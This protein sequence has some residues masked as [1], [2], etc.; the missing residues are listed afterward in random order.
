LWAR[1]PKSLMAASS[2]KKERHPISTLRSTCLYSLQNHNSEHHPSPRQG[3]VNQ[4]HKPSGRPVRT[5]LRSYP[6]SSSIKDFTADAEAHPVNWS[7][8]ARGPRP[9]PPSEDH[10]WCNK[11]ARYL[12]KREFD[13]I[14]GSN[15]YYAQ[16]RHCRE[17]AATYRER[18]RQ[19]AQP[20]VNNGAQE[21][22]SSSSDPSV[23]PS[24]VTNRASITCPYSIISVIV[25]AKFKL[26]QLSFHRL[27]LHQLSLHQLSFHR[28]SLHQLSLHQLSLH[29]LSLHRLWLHRLWST[30]A[31][32]TLRRIPMLPSN[33]PR[34]LHLI[35]LWRL[36][37]W[38]MVS[39][40]LVLTASYPSS[41]PLTLNPQL[42]P[43]DRL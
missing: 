11:M 25:S 6:L 3:I 9:N 38:R 12:H 39:S 33:K 29:R 23:G 24:Q 19:A 26:Q 37:R 18:C 16:C 20:N 41:F 31:L 2:E 17:V 28:L 4:V 34:P 42:L 30:L 27:S 14:N 13:T 1:Q 36:L 22:E 7:K 40:L 43:R 32:S 35:R 21:S 15:N 8:M 10:L 5:D